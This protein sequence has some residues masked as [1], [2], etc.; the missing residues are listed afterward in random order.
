MDLLPNETQTEL[1][2]A[3]ERF[4]RDACRFE[5]QCR[6]PDATG[7]D[8]RLWPRFVEL[9]WLAIPFAEADGGLGWGPREMGVVTEGLGLGLVTEPVTP[10][11]LAG[12]LIAELGS[13]DQRAAWIG[14][15]LAGEAKLALAWAETG[16]RHD[17]ARLRTRAERTAQGWR[18]TGAKAGIPG[19]RAAD[20]FVVS[21]STGRGPCL[22]LVPADAPGASVLGYDTQDG[23]GAADLALEG[24]D[25]PPDALLGREGEGLAPLE[26]T[27]DLAVALSACEA[28]GCIRALCDQTLEHLKTRRQFGRALSENQ[29]LQHRMA[30][31]VVAREEARS[32]AL[33]A[34]LAMADP[35]PAARARRISLAKIEIARTGVRTGQ[36]AVQLHGAMGMTWDLAV[37]HYFKRLTAIAAGF[38][39]VDHHLRRL[40][41][42]DAEARRGA[43]E[44][45]EARMELQLSEE[46]RAFREELRGFIRENLPPE[47]A[48]KVRRGEKVGRADWQPWQQA[49]GRR[50]W[51]CHTWP[52]E[53]GGPGWSILRRYVFETTCA[54]MDCPPIRPFGP[55]MA[56]PVISAFG[57]EAQKARHLPGILSSDVNWCQGYSEPQAGSDLASLTTRA[58]DAGDHY[59]V[60]GQKIWTGDAHFADWMFCLVRTS[61]EDRPQKGISF[62][63]IDMKT[64]GITVQPIHTM[65]GSHHFNAVFFDRVKVPQANRVGE[66]GQGWTVAKY[67]LEHERVDNAGIGVTRQALL[68]L[69]A[70]A[71]EELSD[72]A[73][74]AEDPLFHARIAAVEAQLMSLEA[75]ALRVLSEV[76]AGG[77][78]GPASSL[79]KIRG[80]EIAQRIS[81]LAMEATGWRGLP[82]IEDAP[83]RNAAP[84][85]RG[86]AATSAA[87]YIFRRCMSIYGGSNEIQRNI[88][89]K[90]MLGM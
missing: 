11:W 42:L 7:G 38:G 76:A 10:T 74:L 5:T 19:G 34:C 46:D 86:A 84:D 77:S 66:E 72:D 59:L 62:L 29:V 61:K 80:T 37:G 22:F 50:G 52:A 6:A 67:L 79:L 13:P 24:C 15:V 18:L 12:G 20:A 21:A 60:D 73:P 68:R 90:R 49:L 83:G 45:A 27:L 39:D 43:G 54:E 2:E 26:R 69:K 17:P 33:A 25:L 75:T 51:L 1:R 65:E 78:P 63:L 23:H 53:Q 30:D 35:D 55:K 16:G 48:G 81:E 28:V 8:D 47:T 89:A 44:A 87:D 85:G 82:R 56:G 3:V 70:I 9:G 41:R 71:G 58:E 88:I 40:A 32:A 31:M 64:P 4:I 36:E 14:A 57:T